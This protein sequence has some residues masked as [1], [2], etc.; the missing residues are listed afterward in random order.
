MAIW[1]RAGSALCGAVAVAAIVGLSAAPAMAMPATSLKAKVSGG[2]SIRATSTNTKL[3]VS[4][5]SVTCTKSVATGSI[6]N[7][8]HSGKSPVKV[9]KTTRLSFSNCS[10]I[11]GAVSNKPSKYPYFIE[12]DGKTKS[13]DTPGVIGPVN[14]AV[15]IPSAGCNFTVT[16]SA[17]GY[18][19]NSKHELFVTPKLP[20]G[21]KA[22]E[23]PKLTISGISGSDCSGLI[24]NGAHPT[25]TST[26]KVNKKVKI[27]VS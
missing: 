17:P 2:G 20:K 24:S 23:K 25:Y 12:V 8:T 11:A 16:G 18:Y 19:S 5:Q 9:G 3:T 14:V 22:S 13:G 21:L 6:T 27:T 26:Y 4:G 15:S 1:K 7:G 10:S